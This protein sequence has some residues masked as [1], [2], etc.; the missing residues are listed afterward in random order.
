[1]IHGTELSAHTDALTAEQA[2]RVK[3][4]YDIE[5]YMGAHGQAL[6][7]H[8]DNP[9]RILFLPTQKE[10]Q[11]AAAIIDD[12]QPGDVLFREGYGFVGPVSEPIIAPEVLSRLGEKPPESSLS[13]QLG[14]MLGQV[15]LH[16]TLGEL[17]KSLEQS[18]QNCQIDAWQYAQ[19]LASLKGIRTVSADIDAFDVNVLQELAGKEV[20]NPVIRK[21]KEDQALLDRIHI[22]RERKAV[23]IVKDWALDHLEEPSVSNGHKPKLVLLFGSAHQQGLQKAFDNL[24]LEVKLSVMESTHVQNR[25]TEQIAHLGSHAMNTMRQR[26]ADRKLKVPRPAT[27]YS[28]RKSE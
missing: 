12:M 14:V 18:R 10:Y 20:L 28:N 19:G 7:T 6:G 3:A 5:V 17:R 21:S 4:Q 2:E 15:M 26:F 16:Q 1:M 22:Q 8:A 23:T 24:G 13:G 25:F 27:K 11:E 9:N